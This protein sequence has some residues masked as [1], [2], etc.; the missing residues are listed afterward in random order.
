[1]SRADLL[2]LLAQWGEGSEYEAAKLTGFA[3]RPPKKEEA[4][5]RQQEAISAPKQPPDTSLAQTVLQAELYTATLTKI[6][7][8]ERAGDFQQRLNAQLNPGELGEFQ[9]AA[10][11]ARTLLSSTQQLN[12][13]AEKQLRRHHPVGCWD[14]SKL[15][16]QLGRGLPP[17]KHRTRQQ[18]LRW[19]GNVLVIHMSRQTEPLHDDYRAF[20]ALVHRRSAGRV[21]I[22]LQDAEHGWSVYQNAQDSIWRALAQAPTLNHLTGM[23]VGIADELPGWRPHTH[24]LAC[25]PTSL[26]IR[27]A[28]QVG[29]GIGQALHAKRR[30]T[31]QTLSATDAQM[32]QLLALMSLAVILHPGLLRALRCLLNL[33]TGA[34]V[35]AWN[36]A[37]VA[38]NG[39]AIAV[40]RE[41][42]SVYI[43]QLASIDLAIR[44]Q[45]AE[46]IEAHHSQLSKEIVLEE[47]QLAHTHAPG[48]TVMHPE[49]H[50]KHISQQLQH[51]SNSPDFAEIKAYL[52]RAGHR[53][54][55]A[56]WQRSPEFA[57]A[58]ALAN[59]DALNNAD[60]LPAHLPLA[61]RKLLSETLGSQA[62]SEAIQGIRLRQQDG[63]LVFEPCDTA[64]LQKPNPL[65][66]NVLAQWQTSSLLQW[67]TGEQP[68]QRFNVN[69]NIPALDL[70]REAPIE[71]SDG[72]YCCTITRAQRPR[73]AREWGRNRQ[74]FFADLTLKDQTQTLR[75]IPPGQFLMG[76]PEDEL[77]RDSDEG[78][79]HW[80]SLTE[81][82][83]LAD[84][85]CTQALWQTLMGAN[86]SHFK[87]D[88]LPVER[89][90]WDDVQIFLK[91]LQT[92]LPSG[93][94]ADLP[95]E[96]EWEYACRAGSTT[97]FSFGRNISA[98]QV[99][100]G[101]NRLYGGGPKG[102]DREETVPVTA[103][104]A[105]D[106]G[107][108]QMHGNV[109][110]WCVD[111][112]RDYTVDAVTNPRGA[113]DKEGEVFVVRGGGWF[114]AAHV[115]RSARRGWGQ[116]GH[117]DD[118]R[119]FRF[120]LRST[121][122][123][124]PRGQ[125][126][127]MSRDEAVLPEAQVAKK[128]GFESAPNTFKRSK[129]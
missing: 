4:K 58:W 6:D 119:G 92:Q 85:A 125:G 2:R 18:R 7:Q 51:D 55:E 36:H 35:Q 75:Y 77:G 101:G 127:D 59:P 13:F 48:A 32:V 25:E 116:R 98:A 56:T 11:P 62:S 102:E 124:G 31:R 41:Q 44:Q 12:V 112:Q 95:T 33:P 96:A 78:P 39:A 107:L 37:D 64:D 17:L 126:F 81:G 66:N 83:W 27:L 29:W 71:I 72:H 89:V 23:S 115:A 121:S 129:K 73:W 122:Q 86:P 87:G 74:G 45:A 114:F 38:C 19:S 108:Y 109:W 105:N 5:P 113:R 42:R 20:A 10:P 110:E 70:S 14:I 80:V 103:L 34:E 84:T 91:K 28:S 120:V 30:L 94:Y 50:F 90:S 57:Q 22:Y 69:K 111:G 68:W 24:L 43:D 123:T 21:A 67:R 40:R 16:R 54:D 65:P 128:S 1:M 63:Q 52:A 15:V 3:Y 76:S 117:A 93:I 100:Y 97:P 49:A 53:V 47:T 46:C 106:W 8:S 60:D 118:V 79:Q 88:N 26:P 61:L 82:I 99:N 9:Q 104:P